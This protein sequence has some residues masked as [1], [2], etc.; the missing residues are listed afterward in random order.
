MVVTTLQMVK[1]VG[2]VTWDME[3]SEWILTSTIIYLTASFKKKKWI[4]PLS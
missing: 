4:H 1:I 2:D 3:S